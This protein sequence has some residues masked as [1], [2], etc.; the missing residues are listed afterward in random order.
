[1]VDSFEYKFIAGYMTLYL[2][3]IFLGGLMNV[4]TLEA[5]TSPDD[6]NILTGIKEFIVNPFTDSPAIVSTLFYIFILSPVI[7]TIVLISI[8]TA[9]GR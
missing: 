9:R 2:V 8:N 6:I 5:T 7:V 1:M 3:I 4:P